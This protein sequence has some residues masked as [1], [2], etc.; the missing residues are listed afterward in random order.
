MRPKLRSLVIAVVF[1]CGLLVLPGSALAVF[2]GSNGAIV[3]QA[4]DSGG[5]QQIWSINPDGS[6]ARQLTNDPGGAT[7]PAVC[8]KIAFVDGSGHIAVM[9]LDGQNVVD[10]TPADAPGEVV[11]GSP[12]WSSNCSQIAF[13]RID[14]GAAKPKFDIWVMNAGDGSG[15]MDLT[16]GAV[17]NSTEPA[18]SPTGSSIAFVRGNPAAIWTMDSTGANQTEISNVPYDASDPSWSPDGARI[19]FSQNVGGSDSDLWLVNADGSG[20]HQLTNTSDLE[21][22]HATFS[23]DGSEI[24]V[25]AETRPDGPSQL[26][27]VDPGS[28]RESVIPN[29]TDAGHP[30]WHAGA[31]NAPIVVA[32]QEGL[33]RCK[34]VTPT[35]GTYEFSVNPGGDTTE[36][37]V[38]NQ[39]FAFV[40]GPGQ[41]SLV[42][43]DVA[44]TGLTPDSANQVALMAENSAGRISWTGSCFTPLGKAPGIAFPQA[45]NVTDTSAVLSASITPLGSPTQVNADYGTTISYG[46]KTTATSLAANVPVFSFNPTISGLKAGTTYH[47]RIAASNDYGTTTSA[48]ATFTTSGLVLVALG[49]VSGSRAGQ[50]LRCVIAV[51]CTGTISLQSTAALPARAATRAVLVGRARFRIRAHRGETVSIPLRAKALKALHKRHRLRVTEIVM[52]RIGRHTAVTTRPI[53]LRLRNR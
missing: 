22:E 42:T 8:G 33:D 43:V 36:V 3:Y 53:V 31:G 25:G 46:H 34:N 39:F 40:G 24:A 5:N 17:E 15:Q 2:P 47:F 14:Y 28:G 11:D 20:E 37:Y 50:P 9:D 19:V 29:T 44:L 23:P 1:A 6:G 35:S 7:E 48:D 10:L 45:S 4:P 12:T 30:D 32:P 18:W 21:E 13:S 16:A 41:T 51:A 49:A 52:Q 38:N 26:Y 27:T